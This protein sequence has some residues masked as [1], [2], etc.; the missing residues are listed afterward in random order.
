MINEREWND[1]R[2]KFKIINAGP[3]YIIRLDDGFNKDYNMKQYYTTD[4]ESA[5]GTYQALIGCY[6]REGEE[7]LR[8]FDIMDRLGRNVTSRITVTIQ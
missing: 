4:E 3:G 7:A 6:E 5:M 8:N 2:Y 1:G